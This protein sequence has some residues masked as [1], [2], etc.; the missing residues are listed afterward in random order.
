[1]RVGRERKSKGKTHA[2][3]LVAKVL[4]RTAKSK[5][6]KLITIKRTVIVCTIKAATPTDLPL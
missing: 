1:M 6:G 4:K 2:S 3:C 5:K